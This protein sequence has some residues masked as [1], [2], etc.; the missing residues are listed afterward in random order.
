[1]IEGIKRIRKA[2]K[3]ITE[4]IKKTETA[5]DTKTD[6]ALRLSE[7]LEKMKEVRKKM[8][9]TG[10]EMSKALEEKSKQINNN[11]K[12]VVFGDGKRPIVVPGI[13]IQKEETRDGRLVYGI[14]G[15][16]HPKVVEVK[17]CKNKREA[18]KQKRKLHNAGNNERKMNGQ[19]LKRF[20]AKEK[21][22]NRCPN[23]TQ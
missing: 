16:M 14:R 4:R 15:E 12:E 8:M 23:R 18:R 1:M 20:I 19:P 6:Q 9:V 13:I 11:M 10:E 7:N 17:I 3:R 22:K 5:F 2:F 21:A